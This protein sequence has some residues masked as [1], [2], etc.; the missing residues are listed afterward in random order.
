MQRQSAPDLIARALLLA[1]LVLAAGC[2]G[3]AGDTKAESAPAGE[4]ASPAGPADESGPFKLGN[5][6]EP[7]TPPTLEELEKQVEWLDRPVLDAMDLL[8]KEQAK[9]KPPLT[10]EQALKLRNESPE[11]NE[12]ILATLGRLPE[13]DGEVDWNADINR[14]ISGDAKSTVPVLSSSA[15]ES[16]VNGM[17]GFGLIAFDWNLDFFASADSVVSWQT[18]KD[19]LYD[20][21]VLRDDLTWSDGEPITAHD[22]VFSFQLIMTKEV[23][24]PAQRSGTDKIKWI[25][26]YDDHT[27]VYFHKEALATNTQNLSFGIVPKHKYEHTVAADPTLTRSDEHVELEDAPV[28]GGAYE[29]KS[30]RRGDE[31]VLQRR[32]SYY[33]HK[34]KQVR[35]K[36]YFK[37]V[38]FKIYTSP[39][40]A[41]FALKTGDIDELMINAEQWETQTS[42]DDYFRRNT[43]VY[44]TEWTEFHFGWNTKTPYFEDKRVRQAMSYAMDHEE[45]LTF[46]RYGVD[47]PATGNFHPASRWSPQPPPKPYQQDLAKA[48][49]LLDAAGW[50][51]TDGD[52]VRD[53]LVD[54]RRIPFEFTI[55]VVNAPDRVSICSLLR[56][57]LDRIG[58]NCNVKPLE[59]TVQMQKTDDRTF[60]AYFGGWGAGADPDTSENIWG[61]TGDRNYVSYANP[62]VDKLFAAGRKEFDLEK[63]E[64]IYQRISEILWDDQP[65]TWLFYRTAFYGYNKDLRGYR[66]SPRGPYSYSPGFGS[67]WKPVKK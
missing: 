16:E 10:V 30:R 26:A 63:R 2:G 1:V 45:L 4:A 14:F 46:L 51:D 27:L 42:D 50:T 38:R 52:G 3:A 5:L 29:I 28:V 33:M 37:T 65:Y 59:F 17:T 64:K 22:I 62:E 20:K 55:M 44:G 24:I 19:G 35:D 32:E 25:E 23:P 40:S 39:T 61:S 53:K 56:E 13:S 54:G 8:R 36:P 66:F 34:G 31:I 48:E 58:V 41:L 67:I 6:I 15:I 49:A 12:Q 11:E 9:T 7:F 60:Q 47:Q 21:L 43:K 57:S 18:S